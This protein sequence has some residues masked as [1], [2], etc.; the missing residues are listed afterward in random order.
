[1]VTADEIAEVTIF[2]DLVN[3]TSNH[4]KKFRGYVDPLLRNETNALGFIGTE[5]H[6][7]Y[8]PLFNAATTPRFH[9]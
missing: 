9:T 5:I 6:K 2:A 7:S 1:M 8:S 3:I 4:G